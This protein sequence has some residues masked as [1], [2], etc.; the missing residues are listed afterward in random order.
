MTVTRRKLI[1]VALPLDAINAASRREKSIRHGHP[2]TLHLWWARRPLA[3][4]RAVIFAQMVDDPSADPERFPT[5]EAEGRERERLFGIIERLVKW[6]NTSNEAVLSEARNEIRRSWRRACT[7]NA[8]HPEAGELFNP[9]RLPAFHDPFAGGGALPLE[10]QRLGLEAHASDLNPVAV[11]INKA[12]IEIPPRF[13]AQPPVNPEAASAGELVERQWEGARGLAEDVRHY[14]QWM[15]DEANR[16]IGHLYPKV[17][18][19]RAM[20][21]ERPDLKPYEGRKLTVI[22]WLWA[23]TVRSPDPAF[24]DVPVPLASTWMLS[25]KKGQE[26]YVKPVIEGRGY[27]FEVKA[28]VPPDVRSSRK[29]TKSGGSGS[30]FLCMMSGSPM[31]F[32]YLRHEASSGRMSASLMAIVAQGSPGRV[33]LSPTPEMEAIARRARPGRVPDTALP[34]RALG[35]RVQQY[36]MR[37]WR[38]L[39]TRRQLVALTTFSDLAGEAKERVQRDAVAAGLADDDRPLRD[40]GTG[41]RAYAEAVAVYL[42]FAVSKGANYWSTLCAWHQTRPG[43]VSTFARQALPMVWDYAEAN[44]FSTSSGNV[45]LGVQQTAN[46]LDRLGI[47]VPGSAS[48]ADAANQSSGVDRLSSTDPPYYDNIGYADL[49]D[50]F[51]LWLRRSQQSTFPSL[52]ATLA[53]PKAEELVATPYRHGTRREAERFFLAGMTQA[54]TRLA[55]QSHPTVPVTI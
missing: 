11:L 33:Y 55:G 19:T 32:A 6:E 36:G 22:A 24:A 35:F 9:E 10:A 37:K 49:S 54:M 53:V 25:T 39:F 27:R 41:A 20:V 50:F 30:E 3:A 34:D 48:Q 23:R 4:A 44:P 31:P 45:I 40:G 21:R 15:R 42:G 1:E 13:A 2:S 7:D 47:G 12:M 38:D 8:D 51:Y 52:F 18:V 46:M 5:A 16:R 17:K 26:A 29:G 14:G 28:G 43:I